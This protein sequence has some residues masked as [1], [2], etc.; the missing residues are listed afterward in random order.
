MVFYIQSYKEAVMMNIK[1]IFLFLAINFLVVLM[2]SLILNLLNIQ[3][4]LSTYG[5]NY[6]SLLIFCFLWGMIG[7]FISLLMSRFI[8]KAVMGVKMID[9]NTT[10]LDH[11]KLL[12]MIEKLT[13][14]ARLGFIPQLGIYQS[15]E[16][17]AFATGPTKRKSLVAVSTGLLN[18]M[19]D[20]EI[21]AILGHEISHIANGDMVTMT[22]IQGVVNAFVMFLARVLAF[23]VSGMNRSNRNSN[24][25]F[26]SYM[27]FVYLFEVVFMVL[28][29]IVVAFFSRLREYRADQGG[30][31]LAGK[32]HMISALQSLRALQQIKD[33]KTTNPSFHALKISSPMKKGLLSLFATHPPIEDRITRLQK[34][35]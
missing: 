3:P 10:D 1:R 15:N 11:Q 30:A 8:A 17:N 2:I 21:Q 18:R 9:P 16:V 34:I 22:L 25:S 7:A 31:S 27:L 5:I 35:I 6:R 13:Q 14:D 24:S 28:G 20:S 19:K 23:A 32:D 26:F 12:K 33:P 4:F 29:S